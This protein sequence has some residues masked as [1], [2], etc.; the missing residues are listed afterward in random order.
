LARYFPAP[1]L[2]HSIPLED[3]VLY[4]PLGQVEQSEAS[5]NPEPE[6]A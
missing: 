2:V 4:F 6:G 3:E 5:L 1:Q